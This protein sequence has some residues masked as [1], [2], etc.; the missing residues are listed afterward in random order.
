LNLSAVPFPKLDDS[1]DALLDDSKEE[2]TGSVG[3]KWAYCLDISMISM[4]LAGRKWAGQTD[5]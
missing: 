1:L 2:V 3:R 5:G 4:V